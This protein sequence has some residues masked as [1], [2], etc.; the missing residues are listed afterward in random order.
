MLPMPCDGAMTFRRIE[1]EARGTLGDQ[2]VR[3]GDPD[4]TVGHLEN[5]LKTHVAGG[6]AASSA[7]T[8]YFLLAKY[9]VSM[10]QYQSVMSDTCPQA[11]PDLRLPQANVSWYDAVAFSN[12]YSLWLLR[13]ARDRLPQEGEEVGFVRLPT[14]AEWEFAARGGR[15]VSASDFEARTFPMPEGMDRYVWYAGTDSANGKAQFIGGL[16]PNPLGLHDMLGN[17]DEIVFDLFRL[18]KHSRLHGQAGGYLIRGGD[19]LTSPDYIRTSY[20]HEVPFYKGDAS[21]SS[22]TTGF[23][24]AVA[25]SVITSSKKL[26][27]VREQW[28]ALR[29]EPAAATSVFVGSSAPPVGADSLPDPL[30]DLKDLASKVAD[31]NL[32][33]RLEGL[34][35]GFSAGIEARNEQRD[36]AAREAL[37]TAAIICQKIRDDEV[38][39]IKKDNKL[40]AGEYCTTNPGAAPC[41]L[42]KRKVVENQRKADYNLGFYSDVVIELARSYPLEVLTAQRDLLLASLETREFKDLIPFIKTFYEHIRNYAVDGKQNRAPWYSGCASIGS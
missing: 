17:V 4:P 27:A 22:K 13:N 11:V 28:A 19:F 21:R 35:V 23:R 15:R 36:R 25:T 7:D 37:R 38:N 41:E 32:R 5:P 14:E 24:A 8:R 30:Q 42:A 40:L 10:L 2:E 6:F 18:T 34:R 1:T 16:E 9:E 20:R 26:E 33:K 31:P 39:I 29:L 12:K 3:L